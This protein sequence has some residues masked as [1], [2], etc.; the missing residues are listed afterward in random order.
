M[1]STILRLSDPYGAVHLSDEGEGEPLVLVH[2]VGM[3]IAAW[4][5][6]LAAFRKTHR[7]VALDLPGHGRSDPLPADAVLEDYVAW[8]H[9][10]L[11]E[12]D[13]GRV[14]LAGHSMGALI[15]GGYT[16]LYPENVRR[17]A[18]LN[19]V[20][21]RPADAR[22][23]VEGRAAGIAEGH[24]DFEAPVKRWFR[25]TPD[26]L[27][28]ARQVIGWLSEMDIGGYATAYR[29]FAM[30]DRTYATGWTNVQCPVLVLTADGDPNST[31]AMAQ[32]IAEA[33]PDAEAVVIAGH[34]HMVS[35]T[36]AEGVNEQL[37]R[38]LRRAPK[39]QGT[40]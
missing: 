9:A 28:I 6:Q 11:T 12:L 38:W 27:A 26:D 35:L 1:T 23:A 14:N 16:M 3:Q 36:D 13:L 21:C 37:G 24:V 40:R 31:P 15:S 2:G 7:V 33:A 19:S 39:D 20:H 10:V 32:A 18:V 5:P 29:A 25:D 17:V 22:R 4:G 30:G 34:R 8:L